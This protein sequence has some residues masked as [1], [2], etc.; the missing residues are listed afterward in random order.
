MMNPN[1][2]A[3]L[4]HSRKFW[5][6]MLDLVMGL[7]TYFVAKYAPSAGDD[8]KFVFATVQP[9][10]L[11]VIAAIAYEDKA[12]LEASF[13]KGTTATAGTTD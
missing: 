9:V 12:R 2:F 5:L 11:L 7:A 8:L 6:A 3:S 10:L 13:W 4:L 1:P